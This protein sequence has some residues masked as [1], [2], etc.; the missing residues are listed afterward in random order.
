MSFTSDNDTDNYTTSENSWRRLKEFI[1]KDKKIW[2][3]F[4]C[5]GQQKEYFKEMGFDIIHE[6]EDFFQNNK[7]ECVIDNPPFS[8]KRQVLERLKELEK[9]FM[10]ILPGV[11]LGY[12]YVQED[13]GEY[14]Q[15]IIPKKRLDFIQ[16]GK[17]KKYNPP[18]GSFVFCY[19][20]NLPK[21]LIFI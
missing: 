11:M 15:V 8:K 6:D 21:D 16:L 7:G 17:D 1:P 13:F 5:D 3:P 20:M 14:L 12:K 4:Y 19:K 10:L 18:F 9:P 2:A